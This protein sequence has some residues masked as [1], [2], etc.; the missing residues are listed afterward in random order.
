VVAHRCGIE[1][2]IIWENQV[3]PVVPQPSFY[4]CTHSIYRNSEQP[5]LGTDKSQLFSL[6]ILQP[7]QV[8]LV[9]FL[10]RNG[11]EETDT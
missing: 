3:S 8:E 5:K 4:R 2:Y 10:Q 6:G 11:M 7:V 9:C 1:S